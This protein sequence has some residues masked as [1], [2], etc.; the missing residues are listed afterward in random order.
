MKTGHYPISEI[1][2]SLQRLEGETN[3]LMKLSKGFPG[4]EKN[5]TP[6]MAFI[7]ILKFHLDIDDECWKR[8]DG[9]ISPKM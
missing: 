2:E 6:I 8:P 5:I 4:I 1:R 3:R 7:D 9:G